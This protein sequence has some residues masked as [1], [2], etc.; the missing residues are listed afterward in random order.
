MN[1]AEGH[2]TP[3]PSWNDTATRRTII[4]F[5]ES[6]ATGPDP[7]PVAERVAVF[8]NDGTLWSEKPLVVQLHYV[9]GQWQAAA[10]E[11]PSLAEKQPFKA[12]V[13]GDLSWIGGA[14]EKHYLGDDS[15]LKTMIASL[16]GMTDGV[17]VDAY[18]AS[19]NEFFRDVRH[20]VLDVPYSR[21]VYEPMRELMRYLES[22][23]F[24]CYIVS[25]GERDFMRNV[26]EEYYGVPPER[27]VGSAFGLT[28]DED[29]RKVRYTAGLEFF[30]D[31]PMKPVRIWSRIGR[32]P[33]LACGNSNGDL[34]MLQFAVGAD[35]SR[36][37]L[38]LLVHHDDHSGRGDQPYDKGAENALAADDVT[39]IS[40]AEDWSQV[41]P[42]HDPVAAAE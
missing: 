11:D 2:I 19:V 35:E 12:A 40:I 42:A 26:T 10:K 31:G 1:P 5:V 14:V 32:R 13:T 37:G 36:R 28:Y 16:V 22:H 25:G 4:E 17:D 29:A 27:V 34:P 30:D 39:V 8:D 9:I 38:A 41:F 24:T 7:V 33:L 15:D 23:G 20:P 6:V 3:L 18:A 21:V